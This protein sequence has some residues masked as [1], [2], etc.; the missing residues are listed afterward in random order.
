MHVYLMLR[1]LDPPAAQNLCNALQRSYWD[2]D[3]WT[4]YSKAP[5]VPYLRSAELRE[6][7]CTIPLPDGAAVASRRGTGNLE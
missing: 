7:G 4:Y 5:L 1:E 3:I 6:L 2:E